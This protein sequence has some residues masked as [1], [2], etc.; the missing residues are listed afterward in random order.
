MTLQINV[1][2]RTPESHCCECGHT[3]DAASGPCAPKPGDLSLCIECGSLNAFA[4][5]LML[6]KPTEEEYLDV[7]ADANFQ[8]ARRA[9]LSF[10]GKPNGDRP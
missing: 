3:T 1:E 7:A 4:E 8:A 10:K 2:T 5:N 9:I 6:R